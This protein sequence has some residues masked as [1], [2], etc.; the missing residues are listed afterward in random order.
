M[1]ETPLAAESGR[2]I[3]LDGLSPGRLRWHR[4][5]RHRMA[6]VSAFVLIGLCLSALGAP[7]IEQL[8][9]HDS[10]RVDLFN[11]FAAPS[12]PGPCGRPSRSARRLRIAPRC[13]GTRL[14]LGAFLSPLPRT[15]A[16]GG[17]A[18]AG[19][20]RAWPRTSG[21][22]CDRRSAAVASQRRALSYL[23]LRHRCGAESVRRLVFGVQLLR[24]AMVPA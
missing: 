4:L 18:V 14:T 22:R 16:G 7:V 21:G 17:A 10:N 2:A 15:R 11:R 5:R 3:T 24:P 20:G 1:T 12:S 19:T 8:M 9:G 13:G 23:S 6:V